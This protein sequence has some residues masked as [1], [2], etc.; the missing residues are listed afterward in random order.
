MPKVMPAF[1]EIIYQNYVIQSMSAA[2]T[3]RIYLE[4]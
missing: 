3:R 4:S 1:G 2:G